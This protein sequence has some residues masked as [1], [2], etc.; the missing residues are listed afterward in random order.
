MQAFHHRLLRLIQLTRRDAPLLIKR[1]VTGFLADRCSQM[2]SSISYWVF[3]SIFPLAIFLVTV[4][5]QFLRDEDLK[6]R[7][8]DAL[9]DV[10]PLA[11]VEGREQL[12]NVLAGVST[13][14][15]LL[16]LASVIGLLWSASAMM[17]AVRI[18]VNV[19]WNHG[20]RRPA[21]R[22]KL[23]DIAMV[24]SLGL[25][26]AVSLITTTIMRISTNVADA[27]PLLPVGWAWSVAGLLM[28]FL[29]S[30]TIFTLIYTF[31][32]VIDVKFSQIWPG[33]LFAAIA[34]ETAKHGFAFYVANFGN[35]NAI[36]GSLGAIIV[37]LVFVYL[38]ANILLFGA[39]LASEW[40]RVQAGHYDVLKADVDEDEGDDRTGFERV[41]DLLSSLVFLDHQER[42]QEDRT[43][44]AAGSTRNRDVMVNTSDPEL[45]RDEA[46]PE[47][48]AAPASKTRDEPQSPSNS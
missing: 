20:Y 35:Y 41:R 13:D 10:L 40:P 33:V 1:A 37:F 26:V 43:T 32:P 7:V 34:F 22:G 12:E 5:G 31:V 21:V 15:S 27:I 8:I 30:F 17:T 18:S 38:T 16:G 6:N 44:S 45:P 11:P 24:F 19:A 2:A 4:S 29:I 42:E 25:L 36:Y 14:I 47:E 48:S 46:Q 23:V 9:L 28:P 39:E 3:F